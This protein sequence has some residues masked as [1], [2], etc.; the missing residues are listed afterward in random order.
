MNE[1]TA[2]RGGA[3]SPLLKII[4][5]NCITESHSRR[6]ERCTRPRTERT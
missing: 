5:D 3:V 1:S 4:E 6:K 2:V